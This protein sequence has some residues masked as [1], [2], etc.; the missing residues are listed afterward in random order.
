VDEEPARQ[1]MGWYKLTK[2]SSLLR[3][4]RLGLKPRTVFDVGVATGT[5]GYYGVFDDVRYVLIEPLE[6]SAPFMQQIID[7]YPGSI[8]IQAA[9]GPV[10]GEADFMVS[11]K[12]SGSSF[13]LKPGAATARKTPVVTLDGVVREHA[14]EGPFVIKLDV[15]GYELEVLKGAVGT[16]AQTDLLIAEASLW[17]DRKGRGMARITDLMGWLEAHGFVLYDIANLAR[18]KLDAAMT[19]LDLVFCPADSPLRSVNAY[20]NAEELEALA[21]ASRKDFG[22][23]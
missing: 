21:Q 15:Q 7:T 2:G 4:K 12:L 22:L 11:P 17:A 23:E 19:E 18:R 10:S 16:L 20:R 13:L 6:E 8:A 9:A 1:G 5:K 14:L 3:V